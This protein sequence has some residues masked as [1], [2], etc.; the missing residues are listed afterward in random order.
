MSLLID[1]GANEDASLKAAQGL[2]GASGVPEPHKWC[3]QTP[4]MGTGLYKPDMIKK[5]I[6]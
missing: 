2:S 6:R 5:P 3:A 4:L 1:F